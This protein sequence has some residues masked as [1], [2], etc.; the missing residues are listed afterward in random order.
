MFP[1]AMTRINLDHLEW[2]ARTYGFVTHN[3]ADS[4]VMAPDLAAL[5]LGRVPLISSKPGQERDALE[6][7]L[8][9]RFGAPQGRVLLAAGASEAN[10]C[11]FAGLLSAGDEVLI[12]R[13]GYEPH[14]GVPPLFGLRLRTFERPAAAGYPVLA[15]EIERRLTPRTRL[16][17]FTDLHNPTSAALDPREVHKLS[18]LAERRGFHVL[19]DEAFREADPERAP[20]TAAAIGPSWLSTSSLT[21]TYGLGGLRL[22]WVAAHP[23]VL[24]RCREARH[25]FSVEPAHASVAAGLALLP[26]LDELRARSLRL[27]EGNQ[28]AWRGFLAEV[29]TGGDGAPVRGTVAWWRVGE[30]EAGDRF[31]D[32][33]RARHQVAVTPGRFF[34]DPGGVRVALGGEPERFARALAALGAAYR[35]WAAAASTSGGSS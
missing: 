13:P 29:G 2:V 33:A 30:G 15:D 20:S 3:L 14:L 35:A 31:A 16:V 1:C 27:L 24:E 5:G 34:G 4:G 11:V 26:R 12:E 17:V 9:E 21:K 6:R 19:C 22:G 32:H 10:A 28:D 23:D 7:G 8:G 25:A 18:A